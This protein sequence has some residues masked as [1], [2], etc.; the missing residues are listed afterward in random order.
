MGAEDW[1]AC[2]AHRRGGCKLTRLVPCSPT[3]DAILNHFFKEGSPYDGEP[4]PATPG[5]GAD[6]PS[7]NGMPPSPFALA[8]REVGFGGDDALSPRGGNGCPP[9]PGHSA[10]PGGSPSGALKMDAVLRAAMEVAEGMAYL[11]ARGI[12]HGDLTGANILLQSNPVRCL[13][14]TPLPDQADLL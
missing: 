8:W 2:Q 9:P 11:H 4:D 7:A 12:V 6:S 13:L 5:A 3:Q 14:Q 10:L 1:Q